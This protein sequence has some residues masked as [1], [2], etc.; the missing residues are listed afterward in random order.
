MTSSIMKSRQIFS[1]KTMKWKSTKTDI[2]QD[3]ID[4]VQKV[5]KEVIQ[6][7]KVLTREYTSFFS[8]MYTEYYA[9]DVTFTDPMIDIEGVSS[10]QNN[11]D[12]LA[13]RTFMGSL[14]FSDAGIS[15]HS[16]TGGD[17]Q[18]KENEIV[19]DD[20][21]TR[22]TLRVTAKIL[23]WKPTARFSG[24]SVYKL[25]ADLSSSS[26]SSSSSSSSSS[27][28]NIQIVGQTDYWDSI[29]IL[30]NESGTYN[31][32]PTSVAIQDFLT[33]LNPGALEAKQSGPELPFEL[34]RRGN[35][36]EVR[37]YPKYAAVSLPYK[38][39]DEGFGSLGAFTRGRFQ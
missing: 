33:Q 14:L 11:V 35:G 13:S 26:L 8:P 34:L 27:K 6:L 21:I 36:Y 2:D 18:T 7:K 20:I 31:K 9:D 25:N 37:R 30:P 38:R 17:V 15:L 32:V 5:K 12:M 10:Y 24:I 22:W 19:I 28:P 4:D 16:V 23:P 3:T 39:R 1:G 29:N